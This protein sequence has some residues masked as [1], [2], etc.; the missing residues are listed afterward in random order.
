MRDFPCSPRV[1]GGIIVWPSIVFN[2]EQVD[3][4]ERESLSVPENLLAYAS[5][6]TATSKVSIGFTRA[7][8]LLQGASPKA[9]Y[10]KH[11]CISKEELVWPGEQIEEFGRVVHTICS[12]RITALE[13]EVRATE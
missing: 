6:A 11:Y 10:S 2:A 3:G 12:E 5:R 1:R 8:R 4:Y 7:R 9:R 13:N